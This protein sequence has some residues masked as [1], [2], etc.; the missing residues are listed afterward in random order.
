MLKAVKAEFD[1]LLKQGIASR[2]NA[3][4]ASLLHLVK[5]ADGTYRPCGDY[6][7]LISMTARPT[8]S[9]PHLFDF[10]NNLK[11]SK[12]FSKIDLCKA[13]YHVPMT[14]E[15]RDKT[16]ITTLFGNFCFNMMPFGLCGAP[17]SFMRL[18]TEVVHGLQN[19]FVY[20]DDIILYSTSA[21]EHIAH[22][23]SLFE[24]LAQ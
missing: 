14:P 22:L 21:E 8:F 19:I 13:Y 4:W 18:M 17:S 23:C 1:T 16:T 24:R 7:K 12:I 2:S 15:S 6:R 10:V 5:N 20:L 9:I 11:G 3:N